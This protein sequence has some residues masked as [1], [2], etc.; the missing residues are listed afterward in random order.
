MTE[1]TQ[2]RPRSKVA[3]SRSPSQRRT[4]ELLLLLAAAPVLVLLFAM[5]IL[6]DGQQLPSW[7][8]TI[9]PGLL[10]MFLLAHL[11]VRRLAPAADPALL[12]I[13]FLISGIGIA[14]VLR[15]APDAAY[16]QVIWLFLS[17]LVMIA[18]LFLV[19]NIS[20]LTDYK[21]TLMILGLVLLLLPI[22]I[23]T[24]INGSRIWLTALGFS[25]QPGEIAKV[26]IVLFLAGYLA[27]NREM[28]S[29]GSRRWLGIRLPD[30]RTLAP[31]LAM[32][33]ISMVIVIFQRDLGSALLFMGLFLVMIFVATGRLAYVIGGLLLAVVGIV[34]AWFFFS[35]VQ[36]R[37]AVWLNPFADRYGAGNQITQALFSLADG[38]LIGQGIG[39]G[40]PQFIPVVASDFIFVAIAEE[41]GLLGAGGLLI[42]FL[43]LAVRGLTIAAGAKSDV[44]AFSAVGLTAALALQAFVIVGGTTRLIPMTGVTL[45]FVSQ[46]GSSLLAS[47]IIVALLLRAGDS[48]TGLN[49]EMIGVAGREGGILG[50]LALGKRLT[51]FMGALACLFAALI[52]NLSWY[53]V[54]RAEALQSDPTNSISIARNSNIQL[55]AIVSAD[56]VVLA[57]SRLDANNNWQRLYPQGSLAAHLLG[58][59]SSIYG[60]AGLEATF[61]ETLAGRRGLSS[62]SDL[63][64]Q[65]SGQARPGNDLHLTLDTRLQTTV[66]SALTGLSGGAVVLNARTGEILAL[67]S[68]PSYDPNQIDKLLSTTGDSGG[69]LGTGDSSLYN[70]VTQ[71]LYPPGST[72]KTVTLYAALTNGVAT[73]ASEYDAPSRLQIGGADVTNFNGNDYGHVTLQRAFELSANTVFGQ[74]AVQLGAQRLVQAANTLGFNRS[75]NT[76]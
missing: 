26:L 32:W 55:G 27:D 17:I 5:A 45:P 74:V 64:A 57:E 40:L 28:L 10:A 58:Y 67:A 7:T 43:L 18:V 76:D 13:V 36:T 1:A 4:T 20:R 54:V 14:F 23:G 53:M 62:W 49:T 39:R 70:R 72:F 41:T 19:P 8:M 47:F 21:Y 33:A 16:R 35:H 12:P 60:A 2:Q 34:A 29:S 9:P 50:R 65:L 52:I 37:V 11:A 73:L 68:S 56:G 44:E 42:L 31:L 71:A 61:A 15:L 38:G 59:H 48:G 75:I 69:G 22:F 25:F 3:S 63:L 46:G 24:E 30:P 66:E 6:S 51:F